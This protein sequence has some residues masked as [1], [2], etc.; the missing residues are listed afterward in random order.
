[1]RL[2]EKSEYSRVDK[3]P[4]TDAV[5]DRK[6]SSALI[7]ILNMFKVGE[8]VRRSMGVDESA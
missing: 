7:A 2:N 3:I 5:N 8:S 4:S 1:M 6:F